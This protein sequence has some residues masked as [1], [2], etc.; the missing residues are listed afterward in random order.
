MS[1]K[2]FSTPEKIRTRYTKSK[3]YRVTYADGAVIGNAAARALTM[4]FYVG[5]YDLLDEIQVKGKD[6]KY[7]TQ[8][9][10]PKE[11]IYT[12]EMQVQIVITAENAAALVEGIKQR[13][14]F[15]KEPTE[16]ELE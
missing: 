1:G 2:A 14:E 3:D 5:N 10:E 7:S 12:R 4:D 9:Q 13:L 8:L 6:G 15:F 16:G 11:V